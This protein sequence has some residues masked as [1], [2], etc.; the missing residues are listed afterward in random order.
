MERN[1]KQS[2]A[3]LFVLLTAIMPTVWAQSDA[4]TLPLAV[5]IALKTNPLVR[6][7]S[8]GRDIADARLIEA[9]AAR[10]PIVQV[11]QNITQGNNPVYVFGSL[12]EQANFKAQ[13]FALNAL[14]NPS[15]LHNFR[16]FSQSQLRLICLEIFKVRWRSGTKHIAVRF[17][18]RRVSGHFFKARKDIYRVT[19]H[20]NIDGRSELCAHAAHTFAGR[21]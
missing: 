19:R 17:V 18:I 21:A 4:L 8:T 5:E 20:L 16:T 1:R 13:N 2:H 15:P 11:S 3:L 12:L 14:N 6:A 10:W 9:R 7:T